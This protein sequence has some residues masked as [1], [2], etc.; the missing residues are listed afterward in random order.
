[1]SD[2]PDERG[3]QVDAQR[4]DPSTR[5]AKDRT[6]F[7]KFRTQLSLERTTPA[8]IRTALT[9]ATFGFGT[10]GFFGS[11]RAASP[12]PESIQLHA[13]AIR[14]GM[15]LIVLGVA[16]T[17]LSGI[18]HWRALRRLRRDEAPVLSRWPLSVTLAVLLA[19]VGLVSLWD[20]LGGA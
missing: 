13:S 14:F 2:T 10:V 1:M 3:S 12:T 11:L 19:I 7:A 20:L 17:L 15:A 4:A 16:A 8:W 18:T 9:M 5:L 6:S